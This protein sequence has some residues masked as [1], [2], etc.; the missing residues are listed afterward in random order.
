ML[1]VAVILLTLFNCIYGEVNLANALSPIARTDVLHSSSN[2]SMIVQRIIADQSAYTLEEALKATELSFADYLSQHTLLSARVYALEDHTRD[3]YNYRYGITK[4]QEERVN[5]LEFRFH[6][7]ESICPG[8]ITECKNPTLLEK[9]ASALKKTDAVVQEDCS[10]G[11]DS[12]FWIVVTEFCISNG[13]SH[14]QAATDALNK[15]LQTR[16]HNLDYSF[17]MFKSQL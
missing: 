11:C 4:T 14:V 7:F 3:A 1:N 12:C 17:F 10:E 8:H 13:E 6:L 15:K 16:L 2:S 5:F 9:R